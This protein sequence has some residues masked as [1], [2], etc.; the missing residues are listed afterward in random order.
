[1][2]TASKVVSVCLR[3]GELICGAIVAGIIGHY[4]YLLHLANVEPN[5]RFV[6]TEAIAGISIFFSIILMPPLPYSFWAFPFD[7]ALFICWMVAFGLLVDLTGTRA[8]HSH[9]YWADW[10]YY[11]GGWFYRIPITNASESLIG[12]VHCA[13]WRT[14]NA[15]VFI[16]GWIWLGNALCGAYVSQGD[17]RARKEERISRQGLPTISVDSTEKREGV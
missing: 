10:G 4:L 13:T 7:F 6:Y 12:T 8:C 15:F 1:M 3:V 17:Y 11:W 5:D 16:G 2:G 9:W 14:G